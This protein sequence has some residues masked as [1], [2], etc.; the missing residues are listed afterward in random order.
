MRLTYV[1]DI[2]EIAIMENQGITIIVLKIIK[3][4]IIF[5]K[6]HM[7]FLDD[8]HEYRLV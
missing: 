2:A 3:K 1:I 5:A 8:I 7:I 6:T 4:L